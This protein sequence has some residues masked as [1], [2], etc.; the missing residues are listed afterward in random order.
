MVKPHQSCI[1][2]SVVS[3]YHRICFSLKRFY[4][5]YHLVGIFHE[6]HMHIRLIGDPTVVLFD[7]NS[8][9]MSRPVAIV[10]PEHSAL[11]SRMYAVHCGARWAR[12]ATQ[13]WTVPWMG[14]VVV[15][16]R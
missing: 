4:I 1:R 2:P 3:A 16:T 6:K 7:T 5:R 9:H 11:L 12:P 13:S 15:R 8:S 10:V 14:Q